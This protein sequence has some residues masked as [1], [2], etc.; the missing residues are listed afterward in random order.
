MYLVI[1]FP[2]EIFSY[3]NKFVITGESIC[4]YIGNQTNTAASQIEWDI[5]SA[6]SD[7]GYIRYIIPQTA[8]ATNAAIISIKLPDHTCAI[9]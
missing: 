1:I 2:V 7:F 6:G 4:D 5:I 8:P 3:G 9:E